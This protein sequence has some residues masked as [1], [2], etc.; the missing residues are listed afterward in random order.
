MTTGSADPFE[1]AARMF[2]PATA[3]RFASPLGLAQAIDPRIVA[4][5]ALQLVDDLLVAFHDGQ[6][7]R[8][9]VN[10]PPQEGKSTLC[11]IHDTTWALSRDPEQRIG[12]AS[13]DDRLA[14]R[15][16]RAIRNDI[17]RAPGLGLSLGLRLA[18]DQR[19][20]NEWK[21]DNDRGGV[22]AAGTGGAWSGA[23]VDVLKVDDPFKDRKAANSPTVRDGV[24]EWWTSTATARSP[25]RILIVM[26][27]W[28]WDDLVGRLLEH[29]GDAWEVVNI[30]A[31]ADPEIADPDPLG[32]E[33]GAYMI[34]ARGRTVEQWEQRKKDA[35]EDWT[36]EYQGSPQAPG[37]VIFETDKLRY[38]HAPVDGTF[39]AVCGPRTW[40]LDQCWRFVTMDTATSVR[41][42]A[43]WTVASAWAV[44]SDGSL[45]LLGVARDRV[46]AHKQIDV[47]RPLVERWRPT[48]VH[49]EATM[50]G[51]LLVREA[52]AEGWRIEDLIA[53]TDKIRRSVPAAKRV[54][55]S[56]VWFPADHPLLA[57]VE[58]EM[59]QF[60][61]G[62]HDDFVDTLSYAA[63]LSFT[64]WVPSTPPPRPAPRTPEGDAWRSATRLEV[65]DPG[66]VVF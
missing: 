59:R 62:R 28:H 56:L 58:R 64:H 19:A 31:Q 34:S 48:A 7:P 30:P 37:G 47:A 42:Q 50:A 57:D 29:D 24:W 33:P 10:M 49:V 11:T 44:P 5:P 6:I 36:P 55:G 66:R 54:N 53:D 25:K 16:S 38:W 1:A 52:I 20:A 17:T 15:F 39:T 21:L 23:P 40:D 51:T 60:P 22:Y 63:A 13:Y 26:T 18:P 61:N 65:D 8:L 27:R 41:A 14:R 9:I 32:R 35:D 4:T 46:P 2:D 12:I 45:I 43:D 3:G